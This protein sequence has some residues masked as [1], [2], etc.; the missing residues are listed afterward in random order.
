MVSPF[1]IL[2]SW[3][4]L[5]LY[6]YQGIRIRKKSIRMAPPEQVPLVE[7]RAENSTCDTPLEILMIGDSSAAGVGVADFAECVA[8]R[9]PHLLADKTEHHINMRTCGNNSATAGDLRDVVVPNLERRK[10]DY[11]IINIGTNDA[12]NF[13]TVRRFKKEF[14]GLLYALN[15]RFPGSK[16]IWSGIIDVKGV[17][18]LPSPLNTLMAIRAR[19]IRKQGNVLC[20]E[21]GALFPQT[22][23]RVIPENFAED[24]FHASS[25]GYAEWAEEL[26]S[27]LADL[28]NR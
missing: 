4:A 16:I 13:H 22:R 21:R 5:P 8:G 25:Q 27:Y 11:I 9:L 28:Q 18:I 7:V 1:E 12:K 10:Y 6:A 2:L 19:I 24:G 14:G 17:P 23:W 3:L 26:S 15:A 20:Y